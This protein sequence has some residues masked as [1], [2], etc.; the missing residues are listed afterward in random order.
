MKKMIYKNNNIFSYRKYYIKESKIHG[1]GIFASKDILRGEII[2]VIKGYIKNYII[3]NRKESFFYPDWIGLS[4][5][6]WIDPLPPFNL[7]NH[8]CNPNAGIKGTKSVVA[9]KKIKKGEEIS[10]DYS[11]TEE[12]IFWKMKCDCKEK[13]C[14]KNIKSIQS[15][16]LKQFNK[17]LPY[18]P[19]YFKNLYLKINK[20][21]GK[22]I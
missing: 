3:T 18:V 13:N 19:N 2:G 22:K 6:R 11:I 20:K 4:K 16:P 7:I 9:I 14:R 8:S 12:D 21:N 10:I 5:G 17:Y 15:L 1:M